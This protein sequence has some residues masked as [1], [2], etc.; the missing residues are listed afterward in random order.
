MNEKLHL[1]HHPLKRTILRKDVKIIKDGDTTIFKPFTLLNN[2]N[3]RL[4]VT[5]HQTKKVKNH[6]HYMTRHSHLL[7]IVV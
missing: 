1:S 4:M 2:G 5:P 6:H 3:L 7:S